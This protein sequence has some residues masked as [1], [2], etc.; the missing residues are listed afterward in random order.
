MNIVTKNLIYNLLKNSPIT[1]E[2][3]ISP[4]NLELKKYWK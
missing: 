3:E 2:I 4:R 1:E